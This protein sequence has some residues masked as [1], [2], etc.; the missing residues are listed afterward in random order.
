MENAETSN[1]RVMKPLGDIKAG[2]GAFR[3]DNTGVAEAGGRH[4]QWPNRWSWG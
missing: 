4:A 3:A 1:Q 2:L